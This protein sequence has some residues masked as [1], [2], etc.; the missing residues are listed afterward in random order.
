MFSFL[1]PWAACSRRMGWLTTQLTCLCIATLLKPVAA[2]SAD[3]AL[4]P[5]AQDAELGLVRF[6]CSADPGGELVFRGA[7]L[8]TSDPRDSFE[9][10]LTA[11]HGLPSELADISARCAV[12]GDRG[13]RYRIEDV[14]RSPPPTLS[15]ADDWAVVLTAQR[16]R[17]GH[18]RFRVGR[19]AAPSR[20]QMAED[21]TAVRLPLLTI[22]TEWKCVLNQAGL[23]EAEQSAGLFAHSCRS[24][25]GHSGSPILARLDGEIYVIG[26]H[27][28]SRWFF[29][30]RRQIKLGRYVDEAIVDA[31]GAAVMR[32]RRGN[33]GAW[34]RQQAPPGFD[35][36]GSPLTAVASE[37]RIPR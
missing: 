9:V 1:E 11:A 8:E 7:V 36:D 28:G 37:S 32:G 3:S 10:V 25:L 14:W 33:A 19:I 16:M 35:S 17:G 30:E 20:Y 34:R 6:K 15:L 22:E 29:E 18:R 4:L 27:L 12:I 13:R 5:D 26:V 23:S 21:V 31:I 24:W 2:V